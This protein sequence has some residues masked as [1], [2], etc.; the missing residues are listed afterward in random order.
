[1]TRRPDIAQLELLL[2]NSLADTERDELER[3]VE[4]CAAR[5]QTLE[6]LTD[7]TI[8]A[9]EP[10]QHRCRRFRSIS[11]LWPGRT[12]QLHRIWTV[13]NRSWNL[14]QHDGLV[15]VEHLGTPEFT[16]LPVYMVEDHLER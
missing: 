2:D 14:D 6:G 1:M 15:I 4:G 16:D 11:A 13:R 8:W 3:H 5:Q 12:R 7:A 10:R 9:P